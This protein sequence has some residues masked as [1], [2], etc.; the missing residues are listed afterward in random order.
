M[1]RIPGVVVAIVEDLNDPDRL[2]RIKVKYPWLEGEPRSTWAPVATPFAGRKR[3]AWWMPEPQDECLVAFDQGDFDH[4]YVVGF[5]WNG[6]DRP[7]EQDPRVRLFHSLN[8]HRVEIYDP[9][10]SAGDQGYIL[11]EDAHGNRIELKNAQINIQGVGIIQIQAPTVLING[12]VVAP[13][14]N[15]I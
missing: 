15:P 5:L 7:P 10:V 1:K 14:P 4:P 3:G 9:D 13:T 8:G 11:I 2:G 12:R 6:V